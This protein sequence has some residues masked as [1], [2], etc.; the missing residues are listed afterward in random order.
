MGYIIKD[1]KV[2]RAKAIKKLSSRQKAVFC[3]PTERQ[4]QKR[5][6]L[7]AHFKKIKNSA[8]MA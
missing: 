1:G 3:K 4:S 8:A 2:E 5:K 6:E 7:L